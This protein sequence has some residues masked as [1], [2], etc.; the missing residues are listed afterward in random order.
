MS[1][2]QSKNQ[3]KKGNREHKTA[4]IRVRPK[5]PGQ[6]AYIE[7]IENSDIIVCDGKAG[8]GKTLLAVG[9][10]LRYLREEPDKYQRI[11]MVR[12]AITACDENLGHLPGEIDEKMAPFVA[13]M[14]DSMRLFLNGSEIENYLRTKVVDVWPI[15]FMRGRTLNNCV[16]IFDEAQNA[17]PSQM[18]MFLTRIGQNCKVIIEGDITQSDLKGEAKAQ[19]GL[20]DIIVRLGGLDGVSIIHLGG[21][22]IVRSEI[23]S[24][25]L[26]RYE[27]GHD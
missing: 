13:P 16:A 5:T 18:K 8:T 20:R 21:K 10:A 3:S 11:I 14:I 22:D 1:T 4:E 23:V 2:K 9:R 7:A 27:V 15:A 12:P 24:R 6:Q 19:N 17:T 25:V 26:E